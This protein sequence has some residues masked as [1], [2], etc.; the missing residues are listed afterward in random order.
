M[1]SVW[2]AG[3]T[4]LADSSAIS[5]ALLTVLPLRRLPE[6]ARILT[7]LSEGAG[8][9]AARACAETMAAAVPRNA[10]RFTFPCMAALLR[11]TPRVGA[12]SD[13]LATLVGCSISY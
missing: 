2:M 1:T 7:G 6:R 5:R 10:R 4:D 8:V 9:S 13:R 3:L 12:E 11:W